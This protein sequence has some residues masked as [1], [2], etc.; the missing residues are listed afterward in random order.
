ME[1]A[2][3]VS[4]P[5]IFITEYVG[6]LVLQEFTNR[7]LIILAKTAIYLVLPALFHQQTAVPALSL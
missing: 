2:T 6:H 7:T 4:L 5:T 3:V 1:L